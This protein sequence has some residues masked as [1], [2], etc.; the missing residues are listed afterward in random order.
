MVPEV[1]SAS[2]DARLTDFYTKY[3]PQRSGGVA[4]VF[5]ENWEV[6]FGCPVP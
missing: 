2:A 4:G 3:A 5:W 6:E 1:A